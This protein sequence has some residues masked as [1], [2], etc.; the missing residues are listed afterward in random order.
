MTTQPSYTDDGAVRV[1]NID[2][3]EACALSLA[4]AFADDDVTFYCLETPDNGGKTRQQLWPL[5]LQFMEWLVRGYVHRGLVLSTGPNHEGVALWYVFV[6][7]G[8]CNR[9]NMGVVLIMPQVASGRGE[10]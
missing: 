8:P 3:A 5:H 1:C 7:H 2:D 10:R 6:N 9:R 4:L